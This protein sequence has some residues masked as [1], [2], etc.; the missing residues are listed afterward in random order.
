MPLYKEVNYLRNYL[1]LE[2]LRQHDNIRIDFQVE[3]QVGDQQIAPL[4][5][6]PFLENSFKH[7]LN[8]QLANG[9]VD[10]HLAVTD[11]A[12]DFS[13][14]NSKGQAIVRPDGRPSGG[15]GLENVRRRLNLLY[16][17]RYKLVV[18]N[19]P[20]TFEVRLHIQL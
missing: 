13:I 4:L 19:T 17:D 15:I 6:I 2:A 3:G 5:F 9:F 20:N 1:D 16:P 14:S 7:G 18:S 8:T 12:V 10:I 11:K